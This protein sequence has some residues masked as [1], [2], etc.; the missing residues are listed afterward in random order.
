MDDA[1]E[2]YVVECFEKEAEKI[3]EKWEREKFF[4]AFLSS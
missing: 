3:M 2:E 1:Y 4:R